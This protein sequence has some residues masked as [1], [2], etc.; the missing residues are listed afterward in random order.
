MKARTPFVAGIDLAKLRPSAQYQSVPGLTL[1]GI[2]YFGSVFAGV[3]P[4]LLTQA[5]DL[6]KHYASRCS[7]LFDV[8]AI[9]DDSAILDL[10][11]SGASQVFVLPSQWK[12]LTTAGSSATSDRFVLVWG[13]DLR[14][15]GDLKEA[16][17]GASADQVGH[18]NSALI[19]HGLPNPR[20]EDFTSDYQDI[21]R[22]Y[23]RAGQQLEIFVPIPEPSEELCRKWLLHHSAT[24]ILPAERLRIDGEAT[25]SEIRPS[26]LITTIAVADPQTQ[27]YPTTV[28]DERGVALGLVYS[29]DQSISEA[30]RTG[31]GVY[32]SRKRGLWY[33]GQ[34]SGDVQELVQINLDCD[35]DCLQFVVRQKGKGKISGS[36][37]EALLTF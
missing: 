33:K 14:E 25:S 21:S 12:S 36:F 3:R 30:L 19:R 20:P 29:N 11:N 18:Q 8:T 35:N 26:I 10:L 15:E 4:E 28:T 32:W 5:F 17:R 1:D 9:E 37:E 6:L 31:T 27:L 7:V 24:L 34:T 13:K 23:N 16:L 2:S 22:F